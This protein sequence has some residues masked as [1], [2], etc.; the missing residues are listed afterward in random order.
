MKIVRQDKY[1]YCYNVL[2][3]TLAELQ[4]IEIALDNPK[5]R[6]LFV[7]ETMLK[8]LYIHSN[9]KWMDRY[10]ERYYKDTN[11]YPSKKYT[12]KIGSIDELKLILTALDSAEFSICPKLGRFPDS[13]KGFIGEKYKQGETCCNESI[14]CKWHEPNV[15]LGYQV[16]YPIIITRLKKKIL[17]LI[18][19]WD[20][21]P[22]NGGTK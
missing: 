21:G 1:K 17:N 6:R 9:H 20:G 15:D 11:K 16:C 7:K 14:E 19:R 5:M 18:K 13:R 4:I 10:T 22:V 2:R 12:F 8:K 3:I